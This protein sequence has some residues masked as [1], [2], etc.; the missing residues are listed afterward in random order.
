[1]PNK[2]KSIINNYTVTMREKPEGDRPRERLQYFG[3]ESLSVQE[4]LAIILSSGTRGANA[5]DVGAILLREF[6]GL[7]GL[8]NAT[9]EELVA[10]RGIGAAKASQIKAA[11]E[12]AKRMNKGMQILAKTKIKTPEDA[13][14]LL[15]NTARGKKKEYFWAIFLDT[16]NHVIKNSEISVGSLDSSIVHP[17]ELFKEAIAA[18]AS[19]IIAAH[20]HPSGNPEASQDDIKLSRRLKEAGE[21][22]GIDLVDH[23]IIGEGTF[24]SLKREGLL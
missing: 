4:L 20:N 18:S 24:I 22:V 3:A 5:T 12:L 2:K 1:M 23:I 14:E 19:S 10:L 13:Y 15:K 9:F 17:R 8:A 7:E 16:R 21:L 6:D 11:F